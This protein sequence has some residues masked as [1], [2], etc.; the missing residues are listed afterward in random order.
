MR[1][2]YHYE[3]RKPEI[4]D[5]L[6]EGVDMLKRN[7]DVERDDFMKCFEKIKVETS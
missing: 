2:V 6:G 3:V 5:I 1:K 7:S 4:D